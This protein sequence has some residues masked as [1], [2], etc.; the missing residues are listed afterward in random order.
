M[1]DEGRRTFIDTN[2]LIYAHD[3]SAGAK[4]V[5]A[6]DLVRTLWDDGGGCLSIQVLQEF[7]VN[8]TRKVP[9][10]MTASEAAEV[11]ADLAVW[12]V[13]SPNTDEVLDAI[14]L[15][16]RYQ[17]AFWDA[18]ILTSASALGCDAVWSEDLNAS[19]RYGS[20]VVENPFAR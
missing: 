13:H 19:Q 3:R 14:R 18:M 6:R 8:I 11:I 10:P 2:I 4:H 1:R 9:H 16:Q 7:Y 20:I 12:D 15:S 17:L 5:V